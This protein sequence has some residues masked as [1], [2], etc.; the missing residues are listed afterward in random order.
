MA[1]EKIQELHK[2]KELFRLNSAVVWNIATVGL[3]S[4]RCTPRNEIG[5]KPKYYTYF[6]LRAAICFKLLLNWYD[7]FWKT[8][9]VLWRM[10]NAVGAKAGKS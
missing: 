6:S 3:Y 5:R 8:S 1:A 4:K 7:S 9:G 10:E 2:T